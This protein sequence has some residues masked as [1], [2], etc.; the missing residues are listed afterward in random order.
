MQNEINGKLIDALIEVESDGYDGA[1]GDR[2]LANKAYGPL[3]IRKPYVTD[4]NARYGTS[5][6][7]EDCLNNRAL[8]IAIF[9]LYMSIYAKSSRLGHPPTAE[10]IARM[11]NGGPNGYRSDFTLAY[12]AKVQAH[13]A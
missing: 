2:N 3:Q 1:I 10:D 8:S 7:A 5:F 4:V 12:W 6:K 11:H 9:A 13:L